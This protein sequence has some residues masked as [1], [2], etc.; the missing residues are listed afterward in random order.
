MIRRALL[1]VLAGLALSGCSPHYQ[2]LSSPPPFTVGELCD[3][4]ECGGDG[5]QLTVG[6]ALAF[7]CVTYNYEPCTNVHARVE[8]PEIAIVFDGYLDDLS[9]PN[10]SYDGLAG[11]QPEG[12]VVVVGKG[13]GH[14]TLTVSSDSGDTDFDVTIVPL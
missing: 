14:T 2:A 5:I 9:A 4:A 8:D 10:F 13:V 6:M 11:A 1:L 3:A 12:A 7:D